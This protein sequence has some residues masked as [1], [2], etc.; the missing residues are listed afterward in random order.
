MS[1]PFEQIVDLICCQQDSKKIS[2]YW[3]KFELECIGNSKMSVKSMV[4]KYGVIEVSLTW[5]PKVTFLFFFQVGFNC[6]YRL[7]IFLTYSYFP[8][9]LKTRCCTSQKNMAITIELLLIV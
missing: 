7:I 3:Q 8:I 1:G 5:E 2:M 9:S 6:F 4:S